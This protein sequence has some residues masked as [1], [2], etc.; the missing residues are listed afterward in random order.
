ETQPTEE[1]EVFVV[2]TSEDDD[3]ETVREE[4]NLS[5]P[6]SSINEI[7]WKNISPIYSTDLPGA[8]CVRTNGISFYRLQPLALI[9]AVGV[10]MHWGLSGIS[11]KR[12]FL[13]YQGRLGYK[14]LIDIDTVKAQLRKNLRVLA[15][16]PTES[17]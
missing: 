1:R 5:K 7:I 2:S 13:S 12:I 11:L 16:G 4:E 3:N 6:L 17:M 9:G 14:E 10:D 8:L 15:L